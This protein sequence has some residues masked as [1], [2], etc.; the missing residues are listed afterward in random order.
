MIDSDWRYEAIF[1]HINWPAG[2][3]PCRFF[4]WGPCLYHV[5]NV[6]Y[7]RKYIDADD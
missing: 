2:I 6:N 5:K 7:F 4:T 3:F 1:L